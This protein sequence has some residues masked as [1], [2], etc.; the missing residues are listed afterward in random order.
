MLF[1]S[2]FTLTAP[3]TTGIHV[4]RV[5]TTFTDTLGNEKNT[6]FTVVIGQ[7]VNLSA[8]G[9]FIIQDN[10]GSNLAIVD[11]LGNV[12][13]K[14]SLTQ[15]TEPVPGAKDFAVQNSSGGSNVVITNPAGNM[16]L[17]GSLSQ[18]QGGLSPTLRSFVIQNKTGSVVAYI[19]STGGMFITGT[20]TQFTS[21]S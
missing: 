10:T 11:S 8:G 1:R 12:N 9:A 19:N 13:I 17:K 5:N 20:L 3:S 16:I 18:N 7:S 15:S 4:V 2:N 6:T 14:G 21:F